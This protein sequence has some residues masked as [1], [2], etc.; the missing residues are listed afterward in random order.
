MFLLLTE[1]HPSKL[2]NGCISDWT[3][4]IWLISMHLRRFRF[5]SSMQFHLAY[6]LFCHILEKKNQKN[7]RMLLGI[8]LLPCLFTFF[9][10]L[11]RWLSTAKVAEPYSKDEY[12]W[13]RRQRNDSSLSGLI[14]LH[15]WTFSFMMLSWFR[16]GVPRLVL[17]LKHPRWCSTLSLPLHSSCGRMERRTGT[18][19]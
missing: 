2:N 19:S 4:F 17:P 12:S 5:L 7:A 15:F 3:W 18:K 13:E 9:F 1:V 14:L 8:S 11:E 6:G 10:S 16:N